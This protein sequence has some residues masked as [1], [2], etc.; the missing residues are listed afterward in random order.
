M[1]EGRPAVRAIAGAEGTAPWTLVT[2]LDPAA[3]DRAFTTEAF[4][5]VL[6]ETQVGSED[7]VEFLEAAVTF[8]NE[9]L[10]GSLGAAILA[11][12]PVVDDPVT[13]TALRRA[14]RQLRYGTVAVNGFTGYGFALGTTPWGGFPGQPL[15]DPRSGRG[16][17][18][19]TRMLEGIEKTVIWH[20]PRHPV[21]PPYFPSHRT[22]HRLGPPLIALEGRRDLLALPAVLVAALR[23]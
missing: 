14:V 6:V 22:L 17:V 11:P 20:P 23:G 12:G 15:R 5:S 7:P 2:G 16:F 10:W 3:P 8:A 13:G 1:V 9:R 21:K 18:H 19:N 4:C